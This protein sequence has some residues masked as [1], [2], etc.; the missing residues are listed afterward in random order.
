[1]SLDLYLSQPLSVGP[2]E[3]FLGDMAA[4]G[5]VPV[6]AGGVAYG[7]LRARTNA[8]WWLLPTA[9]GRASCASMAMY[10]PA[11]ASARLARLWIRT[12]LRFGLTAGWASGQIRFD[13]LPRLPGGVLPAL[14]TCSYFTGTDGPH[15]KTAIQLMDA[16]GG[17]LGYAKLSRRA[18]V[19]PYLS[20][21]ARMLDRMATLRLTTAE[22]PKLLAFADPEGEEPSI[23]VT[24]SRK[25]AGV[26]SPMC[27]ASEHLRFLAEM[28]RRTGN[29]GAERAY[30]ELQS[31]G[32]DPRLPDDWKRRFG[33]GLERLKPVVPIMP[34]ALAHGDFTPWNSFILRD[35]LYVFDWEYAAE[36]RPVGYDLVHYML[37]ARGAENPGLILDPLVDQV[38]RALLQGDRATAQ[39]SVLMSLL[40]HAAFYL[41]RAME[42]GADACSWA[43]APARAR[44]IDALLDARG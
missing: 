18:S 10:Q 43:D 44:L 25:V 26:A 12:A 41:H 23:L 42:N 21:E 30:R 24:D 11:S 29:T 20:Q 7:L 33:R 19:R 35:R 9:Q 36:D 1:M 39:A 31:I 22:V 4:V 17:I 13:R 5:V 27:V 34:V 32:S 37:A 2:F 40:L 28:V 16:H 6:T 15:R 38:A 14:A 8:R 3:E